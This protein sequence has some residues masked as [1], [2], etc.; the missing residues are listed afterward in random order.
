MTRPDILIVEGLNV[1]QGGATGA[2]VSDYFDFS[3][4]VDADPADIEE[5]YVARFLTLRG[6]GLSAIRRRTSIDMSAFPRA[7]P[8]R[9]AGAFGRRSTFV[10]L[11]ANILPTRE[12]A[13]LILQK[14]FDHSVREVWLRRR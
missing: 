13:T 2:F 6:D 11:D 14:S 7:R 8:M 10:N 9:R 4:Y 12:R 1:L 3:I 5:W